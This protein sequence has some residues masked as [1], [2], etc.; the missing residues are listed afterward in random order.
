MFGSNQV[1]F[2]PVQKIGYEEE[3]RR[4]GPKIGVSDMMEQRYGQV[5]KTR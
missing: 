4:G 2:R 5:L 1:N 3:V